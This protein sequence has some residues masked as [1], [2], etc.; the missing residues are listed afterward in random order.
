MTDAEPPEETP[1]A[2][3]SD[4]EVGEPELSALRE[5]VE[6][7]YDFDD[8]G[9][10]DMMEMTAEEWEAVFDDEA[11]VTGTE[12]LDRVEAELKNRIARREVFAV[13]ERAG[14]GNDERVLAYSDEGYAV[15]YADGSLEGEG[16]V[17]RD[18]KPSLVL[19][20]MPEFE[21]AEPPEN[22]G[23]PDPDDVP[24]GSGE[25][26]N[27][28]LQI[29]AAAQLIAGVALLSAYF[30]IDD[31]TTIV[32]PIAGVAFLLAG[33]FLFFVVA[34]ARLSDRFRT[35]EYR[36]RLRA[37]QFDD[38]DRPDFVPEMP[39]ASTVNGK[40]RA[41]DG[42]DEDGDYGDGDDEDDDSDR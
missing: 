4:D 40:S 16:T 24:E 32:A 35:E 7:K 41:G 25:F 23:L 1:S 28:I 22:Y 34:N 36:N 21:V 9:P 30:L 6:R 19:C 14:E 8:F 31:L 37:I 5:E 26:G 15:V 27:T 18:V 42:N 29:V 17:F 2:G 20:S 12:L 11:W 3:A 38:G 39:K 33:V 10:E 13:L